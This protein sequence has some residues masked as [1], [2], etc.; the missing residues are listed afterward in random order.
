MK[1]AVSSGLG[2]GYYRPGGGRQPVLELERE[3]GRVGSW[4]AIWWIRRLSWD[5]GQ[6]HN[7]LRCMERWDNIIRKYIV[8]NKTSYI[9]WY[10]LCCGW[11]STMTMRSIS[12]RC[13]V[14]RTFQRMMQLRQKVFTLVFCG[15]LFTLKDALYF[16]RLSQ[17]FSSQTFSFQSINTTFQ[18][19]MSGDASRP[20]CSAF[21][22]IQ[23]PLGELWYIEPFKIWV[24]IDFC[25]V[26]NF[27]ECSPGPATVT[28]KCE[29]YAKSKRNI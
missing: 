9:K 25:F 8:M 29:Y 4:G 7:A 17:F 28:S 27:A 12:S 19:F 20:R 13:F 6:E 2:P 26:F 11:E 14:L 1:C 3:T 15:L 18:I 16:L 21:Q 22:H 10:S 24:Q 23:G 5:G